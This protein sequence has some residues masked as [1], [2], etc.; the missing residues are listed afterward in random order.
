MFQAVLSICI[1]IIASTILLAV[2]Q[3]LG[4]GYLLFVGTI[5]GTANLLSITGLII[6]SRGRSRAAAI[7]AIVGF[8]LLAP[9]GLIGA[10][11]VKGM[12]NSTE[13]PAR[14]ATLEPKKRLQLFLLT[15]FVLLF[16][17]IISGATTGY[18]LRFRNLSN[19]LKTLPIYILL[20]YGVLITLRQNSL[21]LS[22]PALASLSAVLISKAMSFNS[23]WETGILISL[24]FVLLLIFSLIH[25]L[26]IRY[27]GI[28]SVL[29]TF[30]SSYMTLALLRLFSMGRP[31]PAGELQ[32][33]AQTPIY[34]LVPF[35]GALL[36][37]L[38][39]LGEKLLR[40]NSPVKPFRRLL[41]NWS[42]FTASALLACMAGIYTA[43]RIG[44][45]S[46]V[47]NIYNVI[48]LG[49]FYFLLRI[50]PEKTAHNF[51][52]LLALLPAAIAA[53]FFNCM[54]LAGVNADAQMIIITGITLLLGMISY[55]LVPREKTDDLSHPSV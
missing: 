14:N 25:T 9:L 22:M 38:R 44:N 54:N 53:V 36:V 4:T 21:D 17:L 18:V 1:N 12:M 28:S 6:Y 49:F 23:P 34:L 16:L 48:I 19:L 13:T 50:L 31:L 32:L 8:A 15:G 43:G 3:D 45:T 40:K 11:G 37:Y 5:A 55:V 47:L 24:S 2:N 52:I 30:I 39:G 10:F 29:T 35:A 41:S 26:L 46:P 20:S 33:L 42:I 27:T 51:G 7:T